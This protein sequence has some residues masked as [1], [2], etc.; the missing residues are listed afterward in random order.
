[1]KDI[2]L[3]QMNMAGYGLR[4]NEPGTTEKLENKNV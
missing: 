3:D 2:S 4:Q 1:M